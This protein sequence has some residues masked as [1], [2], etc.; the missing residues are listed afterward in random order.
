MEYQRLSSLYENNFIKGDYSGAFK[1]AKE[2][3]EIDPSDIVA[4]IRLAVA[5]QYID[6][7][8]EKL[9]RHYAPFISE[10]DDLHKEVKSLANSFLSSK[11]KKTD[12]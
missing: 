11:K 2:Q 4:Y 6:V 12:R 7:D 3:L 9:K 8:K 5:A 10:K 1:Y